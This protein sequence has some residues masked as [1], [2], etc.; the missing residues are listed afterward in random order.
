MLAAIS[1]QRVMAGAT[2]WQRKL[3]HG[4]ENHYTENYYSRS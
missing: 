1:E 3:L 2:I 4:N